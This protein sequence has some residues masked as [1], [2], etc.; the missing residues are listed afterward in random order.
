MTIHRRV[1]ASDS[2]TPQTVEEMSSG[3]VFDGQHYFPTDGTCIDRLAHLTR[4]TANDHPSPFTMDQAMAFARADSAQRN[5][6]C[7]MHGC[8][9]LSIALSVGTAAFGIGAAVATEATHRIGL[10]AGA[11]LCTGGSAGSNYIGAGVLP[12][13]ASET[14]NIAQDLFLSARTIYKELA[15]DLIL[16]QDRDVDTALNLSEDL[17]INGLRERMQQ[18][19]SADQTDRLVSPITQALDHLNEGTLPQSRFLN[20]ALTIRNLQNRVKAL[21]MRDD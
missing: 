20:T 18:Y 7:G 14:A 13:N 6:F 21:E 19:L 11:C 3:T 4:I 2:D 17:D 16:L 8:G 9:V 12:H 1:E 5:A 15:E 10:L